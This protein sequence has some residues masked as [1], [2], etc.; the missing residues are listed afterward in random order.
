[1][2][3]EDVGTCGM[4]QW[5][6]RDAIDSELEFGIA[7]LRRYCGP[8]PRGTSLDI[9]WN[10]HDSGAYATIS[11]VWAQGELW[12]QHWDYIERCSAALDELNERVDWDAFHAIREAALP[13][14]GVDPDKR[15]RRVLRRVY[16]WL[17]RG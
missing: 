1:M 3:S 6:D 9:V 4:A 14:S 13:P 11:L 2:P 10:D 16:S 12:K 15:W 17:R 8:E 7:C 5:P